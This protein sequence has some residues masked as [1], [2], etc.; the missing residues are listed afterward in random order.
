MKLRV[1]AAITPEIATSM[2]TTLD[3]KLTSPNDLP[4][5]IMATRSNLNSPTRPQFKA[6]T[7]AK[8]IAMFCTNDIFCPF[9]FVY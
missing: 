3:S 1:V 4:P 9:N 8:I 2:Y 6:P 7:T 5:A